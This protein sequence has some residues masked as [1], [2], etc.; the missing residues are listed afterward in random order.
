M[1]PQADGSAKDFRYT[2]TA[3]SKLNAF[4][5]KLLEEKDTQDNQNVRNTIF[6]ALLMNNLSRSPVPPRCG[7]SGK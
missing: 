1:L 5:P 7:W 3:K 4:V 6:G 2:V